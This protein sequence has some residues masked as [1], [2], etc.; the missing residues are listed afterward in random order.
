MRNSFIIFLLLLP[1]I[2]MA[3]NTPVALTCT[4]VIMISES[5]NNICL[6]STVTFHAN[7]SYKG[8]NE[9]YKWQKNNLDA[10]T[11][12][13]D[14][15]D[16]GIH[17]GD[18]ISCEYSCKTTCGTDTTVISNTITMHVI[19]D[20]APIIG[21]ANNDSII[22]EG[23]PTLFTT[24]AFYGTAIPFYQWKLNDKPIADTTP[25]Y[26][27][28]TIT[29]GAKVEC[30]LTVS[31][32]GCPNTSKSATSWMTIYVYPMVHPAITIK[33]SATDICRGEQVTFTATANGGSSPSL[34]WEKNGIATG[35][36]GSI[37][38]TSSL[39]DGDTISCTVTIDTNSRCHTGTS[40]P[41][42]KVVMHVKDY[43]DPTVTITAPVTDACSGAPL[44][45]IA[46][47][48]NQGDYIFYQWYVNDHAVNEYSPTFI[49]SDLA[50]S[51]KVYCSISTNVS[52]C[53][54]TEDVFSNSETVTI[55]DTPVITFS[56]PDTSI[57]AGESIRLTANVSGS[58]AFFIWQPADLL[59]TPQ[60]LISNT[61]PLNETTVFNLSVTDVH[62]C[63]ASSDVTVKMLYKMH[64]PSAFTPNGDGLNDLFR[65]PPGS[66]FV[67]EQLA[68]YDRWGHIIFSAKDISKG[69]DGT[70]KGLEAASGTYIYKIK[71]AFN[72][73]PVNESGTITLIR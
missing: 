51:D 19:N 48:K 57:L 21:V 69:W 8:T 18:I 52:G 22:C 36:M 24:Q 6:D 33:P 60:S 20:V 26:L 47:P 59:L 2:L 3:T 32:P 71:G 41:S 9:I 66:S 17:E 7:V 5:R 49:T 73:D 39:K 25:V 65:I 45:F 56:P 54:I 34:K 35:D 28:D 72:G 10:G 30:V 58:V 61:Q 55:R 40:A 12:N 46:A 13:A 11:N 42:N 31:N 4:P 67:L 70:I 14:Y 53:S 38:T 16:A 43:T 62:G 68:V 29:N 1:D 23:E 15:T 27:T 64:L 50:N 37:M 44:S 63:K